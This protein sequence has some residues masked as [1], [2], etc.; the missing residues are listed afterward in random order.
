M[1]TK[2]YIAALGLSIAI[3][4]FFNFYAWSWLQSK[5]NPVDAIAGFEYH[6]GIAWM[7]I[8]ITTLGLLI[9]GN[10]VLWGTG[11]AWAMWVTFLYFALLM[12][13][14]FFWLG[15]GFLNFQKARGFS[16]DNFS[17]APLF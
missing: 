9:L 7:V 1:W 6:F 2:I 11:R 16:D 5:G 10:A 15:N 8:W 3:S 4:A 17:A 14:R 13:L 12:V